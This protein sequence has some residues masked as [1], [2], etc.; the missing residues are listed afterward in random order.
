MRP[1]QSDHRLLKQ[2]FHPWRQIPCHNFSKIKIPSKLK[3][4]S[5]SKRAPQIASPYEQW[6]LAFHKN[7][8]SLCNPRCN[9]RQWMKC[10]VNFNP[11]HPRQQSN[12]NL[13]SGVR[14]VG[15][16]TFSAAWLALKSRTLHGDAAFPILTVSYQRCIKSTQLERHR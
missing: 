6:T 10:V 1:Q 14:W 12:L 8:P 9:A 11:L 13:H 3:Q 4:H 16:L 5:S 7:R 15:P 2:D